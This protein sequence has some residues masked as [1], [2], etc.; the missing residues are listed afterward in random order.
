MDNE[1]YASALKNT[2]DEMQK[3]CPEIKATFALD[4]NRKL[5]ARGLNTPENTLPRALE[6]FDEVLEKAEAIGGIE[7]LTV[8]GTDG[9]LTISR[10]DEIYLVTVTSKKADLNYVNTVTGV[11]VPTVLK[12][13]EKIGPALIKRDLPTTEPEIETPVEVVEEPKA[14]LVEEAEQKKVEKEAEPE[15]KL[16]TTFAEPPVNQFIVEEIK[17]LLVSSDTV[18][19]DNSVIEKWNELYEGKIIEEADVETFA[20]KSLRCKVKP[21]KDD[22]FEGQGKIQMPNKLLLVLDIKKGELVRVKPAIE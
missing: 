19:I 5:I 15:Q 13:I 22:R 18:R 10:V 6:V 21:I 12:L 11:L 17:G 20:G 9:R 4:Q 8:Q 7:A 3:I 1:F 2:L 14:P 16:D